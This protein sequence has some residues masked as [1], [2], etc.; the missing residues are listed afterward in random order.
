MKAKTIE[1]LGGFWV[2]PCPRQRQMTPK[3]LV[4]LL[5]RP[6]LDRGEE[7]VRDDLRHVMLPLYLPTLYTYT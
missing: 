5:L 2:L 4:K 6:N 1:N 7:T 3:S